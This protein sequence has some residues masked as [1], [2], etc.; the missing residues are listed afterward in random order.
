M[1]KF[2]TI[3]TL[4]AV[5]SLVA[6]PAMAQDEEML[7]TIAELVVASA[8]GDMPEF[9]ILLAAVQAADPMFLEALL[10]PEGDFT[11]FAPTDAAFLA[12]LEALETTPEELLANTELLN[13]VLAY[14]VVEGAAT[15]DIVVTVDGLYVPTLLQGEGLLVTVTEDGVFVDESQV[16][17]VDIMASNGVV[18]VID[19]VLI[20]DGAPTIA[21]I[22]V[23]AASGEEMPEFTV[24]LAAVLAADP[25]VLEALSDSDAELTVFAPTDAAFL[26]LLEALGVTAEEL[27][28]D[29]ELVTNVLLY[30]VIA[31]VVPAEDVLALL[32]DAG[33]EGIEVPTLLEGQSIT[34]TASDMGVMVDNA[35]VII[36]DVFATNG[37]IHVIDAVILPGE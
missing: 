37:V 32:E 13:D 23:Q 21:Q 31:G 11:V 10:D 1:R 26:A 30:H 28:A 17:T 14:H 8:T 12:L 33:E 29:T 25:A 35:N 9:T 24:L 15:S 20:P 18:H 19:A 6:V 5:L 3:L 2:M 22:V 36:T 7:P 4:I 16:I 34:I 27:L